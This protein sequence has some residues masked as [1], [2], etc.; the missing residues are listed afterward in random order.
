MTDPFPRLL[1][2]ARLLGESFPDSPPRVTLEADDRYAIRNGRYVLRLTDEVIEHTSRTAADIAQVLVA[3][4]Y[5]DALRE[6]HALELLAD[7][8]W[9][10]VV[11]E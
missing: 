4:G 11:A 8:T 1:E 2:L 7:L 10:P 6:H 3:M 5:A 9:R